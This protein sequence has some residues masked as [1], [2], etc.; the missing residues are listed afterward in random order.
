MTA[1]IYYFSGTGNSLHVARAAGTAF[2]ERNIVNMAAPGNMHEAEMA[3]VIGFVFPV[4]FWDI[5]VYVKDFINGLKI[6]GR[7]YVFAIATCGGGPGKTLFT[8]EKLLES[9]GQ[10]LAAGFTLDMPDNAYVMAN[11]ITPPEDREQILDASE[12][13]LQ[14]ITKILADMERR[15]TEGKNSLLYTPGAFLSGTVSK[16]IYRMERR[17]RTDEICNGCGICQ[18]ICPTGNIRVNDKIVTWGDQ[19]AQCQACF[20]WCPKNAIQLDKKTPAIMR[21]HHPQIT[22]KDMLLR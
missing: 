6:S 22:V 7:P 1:T 14:Q 16:K 17:Y 19:C 9:K 11:L 3:D 21:Y 4:H 15:G 13:R 10:Q 20:H 5:P 2:G 8:L 12:N 18:K